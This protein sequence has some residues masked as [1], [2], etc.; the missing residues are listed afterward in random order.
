MLILFPAGPGPNCYHCFPSSSND[1][2]VCAAG[3]G[4]YYVRKAKS[5]RHC[6][7]LSAFPTHGCVLKKIKT[8]FHSD[9]SHGLSCLGWRLPIGKKAHCLLSVPAF[10]LLFGGLALWL[11]KPASVFCRASIL[12]RVAILGLQASR[13]PHFT[14]LLK[15]RPKAQQAKHPVSLSWRPALLAVT[16]LLDTAVGNG[17][18]SASRAGQRAT[19]G[20]AGI[21]GIPRCLWEARPARCL[22]RKALP[23]SRHPSQESLPR[24][25]QTGL[26][27]GPCFMSL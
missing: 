22:Q 17:C 9:H 25:D 1:N 15:T 6:L 18:M 26:V 7:F 11:Q 23:P 20:Q 24:R 2:S 14:W 16:A 4:A 21:P 3:K 27:P 13:S 19:R 12:D 10:A 5:Q 8:L